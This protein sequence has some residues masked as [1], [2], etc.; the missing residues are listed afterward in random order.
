MSGN[1]DDMVVELHRKFGIDELVKRTRA[2][3][4]PDAAAESQGVMELKRKD[5]KAEEAEAGE[6]TGSASDKLAPLPKPGDAYK[7]YARPSA[8]PLRTLHLI[9]ADG[10]KRGFAYSGLVEG[11]DLLPADDP[12]KGVLIVLR[13]SASVIVDVLLPGILLDELHDYLG[14]HRIRWVR[15]LPRGKAV[16]DDGS[17]VV[18]GIEIVQAK[19][20]PPGG[21]T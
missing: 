21:K 15:E 8:Q 11:P 16:R 3:R 2:G 14:E 13:F 4:E 10:K 9:L 12:G 6:T 20:W 19:G 1:G 17:S 18:A 5:A 7:A